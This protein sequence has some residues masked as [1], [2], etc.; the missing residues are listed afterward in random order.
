LHASTWLNWGK[1]S[2]KIAILILFFW[3]APVLASLRV[4]V[5]LPLTGDQARLGQALQAWL[6]EVNLYFAR[7]YGLSFRLRFFDSTSRCRK[8]PQIVEK[9]FLEGLNVL[10]GPAQP[11]CAAALLKEAR[12]LGVPA[13][14]TSG[15]FHPVK[16]FRT[17]LGP[18]FRTGLSTRAAVKVL[19]RCFKKKGWHKIGLLLTKDPVGREG[20]RWLLAY[21][22][23]FAL[24]IGGKRYFGLKDTDV[25]VHLEALLSCDAVV[26]WAPPGAS[27]RVAKNLTANRFGIPVYFSHLVA[28]EP[29]LK[30]HA[31]LY[32]H[33]FVGAAFFSEND[34]PGDKGLKR[35]FEKLYLSKTTWRHPVFAAYADAFNFL[36]IGVLK[37]GTAGW[38]RGL[39]RAGLVKGLTGLYFLSTDDH[40]GLL[41]ASVGVFRYQWFRYEPVCKPTANIF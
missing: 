9:A 34:F 20:E 22:T 26:C 21:A 29:F 28:G 38:R 27:Y 5:I 1:N 33:P 35:L 13:V 36:R 10:V 6:E 12:R 15:D 40:Y 23:E 25:S 11:A 30:E 8:M 17:P 41:P 19:Y 37:G 2:L 7:N 4:G 16:S 24:K 32:A 14:I 3:S 39:E 31:G 18:Y